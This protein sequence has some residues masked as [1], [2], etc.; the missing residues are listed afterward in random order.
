MSPLVLIGLLALGAKPSR[1]PVSLPMPPPPAVK[2]QPPAPPPPP[3]QAAPESPR[4]AE[5]PPSKEDAPARQRPLLSRL[6]V[7]GGV[8]PGFSLSGASG[9]LTP[10]GSSPVWLRGTARATLDL[11]RVGP[12]DL[13]VLLP[14][15]IQGT[16][17][18]LSILGFVIQG[19]VF[20]FDVMPSVRYQAEIF[21]DLS[22]HAELGLGFGSFQTTIQQQ[23]VGYQHV[24]AGGFGIRLGAGLEYKVFDQLRLLLQPMELTSFTVTS[25]VTQGGTTV[26]TTASAAEWAMVAG[27][28]VPLGATP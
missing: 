6:R 5:P 12:G 26:T 27:V 8:G 20:A 4:P 17:F 28:V 22:L 24:G 7:A 15:G 11:M 19:S 25:T 10:Q 21:P 14:I 9:S 3:P 2:P 1:P 13:Q 18:R 23:F 16:S